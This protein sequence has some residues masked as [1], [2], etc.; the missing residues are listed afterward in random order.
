MIQNIIKNLKKRREKIISMNR[1]SPRILID[2]TVVALVEGKKININIHDYNY[3]YITSTDKMDS[4]KIKIYL[5][6]NLFLEFIYER[7]VSIK[8]KS[9]LYLY[10]ILNFE[11]RIDSSHF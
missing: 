8:N 1:K 9:T 10:K 4:G 2:K 7:D 6:N 5:K 3:D 11:P